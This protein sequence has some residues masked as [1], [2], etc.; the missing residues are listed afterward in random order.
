M[1]VMPDGTEHLVVDGHVHV[2]KRRPYQTAAVGPTAYTVD[3]LI[4]E[5]NR[6]GVDVAACFPRAEP[7]T[8]YHEPNTYILDAAQ[9]YPGRIAPYARINPYFGGRCI[10]Q[11]DEYV[12]RGAVAIKLHPFKDF[13]ATAVNSDVVLPIIEYAAARNL[14]VL[15]HSGDVWNGTPTLIGDLA[16]RYPTVNFILGHS[17][18]ELVHDAIVIAKRLPGHNYYFDT[19]G[20]HNPGTVA[21]IAKEVGSDRL[22]YGSDRPSVPFGFEITKIARY[23]GLDPTA[24]SAVLGGTLAKLLGLKL[25]PSKYQRVHLSEVG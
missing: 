16:Y 25:D 8:D 21:L 18:G 13:G 3:V 12:E 5:M 23:A 20:V 7:N 4:E 10:E 14:V 1:I 2:G 19:A 24:T 9:Q 17:G 6:N 22:V 11:L 15:F